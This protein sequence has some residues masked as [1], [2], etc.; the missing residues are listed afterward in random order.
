MS[1]KASPA[2]KRTADLIAQEL[3]KSLGSDP[4]YVRSI[5]LELW[6]ADNS[7]FRML[8]GINA[9]VEIIYKPE[10]DIT[11]SDV[12]AEVEK[13][14]ECTDCPL[15][16]G[17]FAEE[18]LCE[19]NPCDVATARCFSTNG[20]FNCTCKDE[21]VPTD[22]SNR[23]CHAC[24][25]GQKAVNSECIDCPFGYSGF[26]CNES[27]Q[28]SL[29]IVGS[30]LGVLLLM[31]LALLPLVTHKLSKKKLKTY[32]TGFFGKPYANN[33][34]SKATLIN[35]NSVNSQGSVFD[36]GSANGLAAYTQDGV[37]RLPRAKVNNSW[38]SSTSLETAASNSQQNLFPVGRNLWLNNDHGGSNTS[39]QAESQNNPND[40]SGGY[41]NPYYTR[42]NEN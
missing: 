15:K 10:S 29:V 30:V 26:N 14:T 24:P 8:V 36:K 3:D 2:F 4:T 5:V 39:T 21:Y 18:D 12:V 6:P 22:F 9:S 40:Q 41:N 27:W 32:S 13:A 16:G 25:S 42:D 11:A 31:S 35:V 37:I 28:L 7:L 23:A 20:N 33:S 38:K 34:A 1:D 19:R 17:T